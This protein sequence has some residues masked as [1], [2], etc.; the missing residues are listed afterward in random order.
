MSVSVQLGKEVKRLGVTIAHLSKSTGIAY[1]KLQASFTG[2]REL[3][4]D[5]Y[6]DLCEALGLNPWEIAQK[7]KTA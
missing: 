6:I 7:A 3:F 4:A 2:R 5:E 1:W